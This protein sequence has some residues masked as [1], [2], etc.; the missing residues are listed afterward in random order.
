MGVVLYLVFSDNVC[1]EPHYVIQWNLDVGMAGSKHETALTLMQ[2]T[3]PVCM[4]EQHN[5]NDQIGLLLTVENHSSGD[6]PFY[7][8]RILISP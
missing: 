2:M 7:N 8:S 1:L 4:N 3:T 5:C 6:V